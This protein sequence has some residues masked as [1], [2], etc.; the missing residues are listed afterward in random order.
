MS[1]NEES[2]LSKKG[3]FSVQSRSAANARG[4]MNRQL[5]EDLRSYLIDQGSDFVGFGSVSRLEGAPGIMSPQRYL[6]DAATM[7]SIGLRINE[8]C[9]DLISRSVQTNQ[10]PPSY[11]SY[12]MFT[13]NIINPQ[14]DKL[15]YLG[16]KFLESKGY[17]AYPFPAN[18]PHTQKPTK[19]YPGGPGDI[20][21]KHV[22]VACGLGEIGWHN[23]LITSRYGTRQ[24]VTTIVTNAPLEPDPVFEGTLCDPEACGFQC[25]LACPT[26]A[27]PK[28]M[29]KKVKVKI[30]G[31]TFG[32]A[33]LVGWRCRWGCSG[34][35]K[36]TGGYR[37]IPLPLEEPTSEELLKY[38]AQMDP[39][40]ERLK[41]YAG[42][43][44]YCGRCLSIC[45]CP[46]EI[47]A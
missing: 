4:S 19:E 11:Y 37:D 31:R 14:L 3:L 26:S 8:A 46:N 35:L 16:A 2:I 13:L 22:A 28:D 23:L 12:Q 27:I 10:A 24:K 30:G 43:L 38:K 40:Q 5:L 6:P 21:H 7:I 17:R 15:T 33:K 44:P 25:A 34:M 39:W 36:C 41:L 47:K 9:C 20:S 32:Y 42:L 1:S 18:M 45:P 29:N